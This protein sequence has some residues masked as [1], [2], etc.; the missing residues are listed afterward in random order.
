M[1]NTLQKQ[2][3]LDTVLSMKNHP[4]ADEIYEAISKKNPT[5]SRATVYRNLNVLS[6]E[7]LINH[8]K[9][10]NSSDRYDFNTENHYHFVC[11]KCN[12]VFDID[13]PYDNSLDNFVKNI[14]DFS[15]KSHYTVFSGICP[16]CHKN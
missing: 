14:K 5:I 2:I 1:R 16:D 12:N 3:V 7:N 10:A 4:S 6:K 8:I 15:V 11:E 9:I 13:I